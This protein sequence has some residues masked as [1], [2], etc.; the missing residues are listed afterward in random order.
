MHY[1]DHLRY[2]DSHEYLHVQDWVSI[3][4]TSFAIEQLGDIVFV[5]L[6]ELGAE[7]GKD[8]PFG[9]V[10]SVKA[11]EDLYAPIS[12]TVV[13]INQALVD[14]PEK[15]AD[16]PYGAGWLIQVQPTDRLPEELAETMTSIE[17]AQ[18][19]SKIQ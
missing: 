6:P 9:T 7:L 17:Y 18:R 8:Q 1:P 5:D 4:I 13:S 12:G 2:T 10:E 14:A 3:G 19:V 16:D 15:I 11:V